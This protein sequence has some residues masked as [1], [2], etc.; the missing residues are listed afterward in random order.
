MFTPEPNAALNKK[1]FVAN[2]GSHDNRSIIPEPVSSRTRR[3]LQLYKSD[4]KQIT[5]SAEICHEM[6]SSSEDENVEAVAAF[7]RSQKQVKDSQVNDASDEETIHGQGAKRATA[8]TELLCRLFFSYYITCSISHIIY[9]VGSFA[10]LSC[11]EFRL[12]HSLSLLHA[13]CLTAAPRQ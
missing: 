12:C 13:K 6:E 2:G 4:G 1:C 10:C 5:T 11:L 3:K 9:S 7:E 8:S